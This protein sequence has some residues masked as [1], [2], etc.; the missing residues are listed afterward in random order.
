MIKP[1]EGLSYLSFDNEKDLFDSTAEKLQINF[2]LDNSQIIPIEG[3][4]YL[5]LR[6]GVPPYTVFVNGSQS[7]S[8]EYIDANDFGLYN[9]VVR[10]AAGSSHAISVYVPAKNP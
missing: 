7:D 6:G 9:I 2:P 10:D 1:P 4:I 3:R 8:C 5:D